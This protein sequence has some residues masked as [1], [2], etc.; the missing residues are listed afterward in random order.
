[1]NVVDQIVSFGYSTIDLRNKSY[2]PISDALGTLNAVMHSVLLRGFHP[3]E[4]LPEKIIQIDSLLDE[5]WFKLLLQSHG[6]LAK[7]TRI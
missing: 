4:N 5:S 6:L 2:H 7:Y 1:M 3:E